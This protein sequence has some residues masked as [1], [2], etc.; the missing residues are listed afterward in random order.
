M[1]STE[2]ITTRHV[3]S[4]RLWPLLVL[5]LGGCAT[6]S[7]DQCQSTEWSALGERDAYEG[8]GSDRLRSHAKACGEHGLAPDGDAYR[9]GYERGLYRFCQPQRG[10]DYGRAGSTYRNTCPVELDA[11]F[12]QGYRLGSAL[13]TEERRKSSL[14]S[15]IRDNERK[16]RKAVS[17]EDRSKLRAELRDM[18]NDLIDCNRQLRR[19]DEDIL[20][21]GLTR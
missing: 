16:L 18:D 9:T 10:F 14:E 11:A 7:K 12:Q 15:R 4:S 6:L 2:R 1:F 20:R 5:L 8:H 13:H 17:D 21:A 19:F 3:S